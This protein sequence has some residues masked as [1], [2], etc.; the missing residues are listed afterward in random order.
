MAKKISIE[1]V[2]DLDGSVATETI[3][4][5]LDNTH[6]DVDLSEK[7]AAKLRSTLGAFVAAGRRTGGRQ[8]ARS[9]TKKTPGSTMGVR[10]WAAAN[11]HKVSSRGRI[12][13]AVQEAYDKASK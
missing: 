7:N 12:P 2:D 4:F 8:V 3:R 10:A 6:Y 5:G 9:T 11:G 13:V 1:L